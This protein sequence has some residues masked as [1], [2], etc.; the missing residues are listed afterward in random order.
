MI[1][2][3]RLTL[4]NS[5]EERHP[6][7]YIMG[8]FSC[9]C[10][11]MVTAPISKVKSGRKRSCGCLFLEVNKSFVDTIRKPKGVAAMNDCYAAYMRGAKLRNY[12][13]SLTRE[14]FFS[15]IVKPCIYCSDSLTQEK[16]TR[17]STGSFYYTGI[18]R[19]DNK[20]GYTKENSV[21]CC[22]KCN[23]IKT[24]MSIEELDIQLE[25]IM[26]NRNIWLR[27]A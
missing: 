6:H 11:S 10:G 4:V 5:L 18:D 17:S 14:E 8:L 3:N 13:F 16:K 15:I 21:P 12:E 7:G 25:K 26:K 1:H 24:D 22:K 2:N 20:K 19:Y 9:E 27:T 23:R